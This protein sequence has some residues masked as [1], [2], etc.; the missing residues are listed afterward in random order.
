MNESN[1]FTGAFRENPNI[2]SVSFPELTTIGNDCFI[3]TFYNATGLTTLN[4][5]KLSVFSSG[6][7]PEA[8]PFGSNNTG[9]S[10]LFLYGCTALT[11]L[12]IH[13]NC[14]VY[15][16]LRYAPNITNL[17]ITADA[18]DNIRLDWQSSLT[19]ASVL[20]VLTH[21]D[22]NTSGKSV[23]FYTN[24]LSVIDD[25]Q[26]SIRIAYDNAVHAGWTINNLTVI[27]YS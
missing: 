2:T 25:A 9:E 6:T 14:L 1:A 3:K 26:D 12:T 20:S 8:S 27:A 16:I 13:P 18:T 7:A 24:G 21:L 17:T 19:E 5:P 10:W 22:L 23:T 11:N 15:G 4:L